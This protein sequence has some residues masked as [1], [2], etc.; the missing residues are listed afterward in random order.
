M[1]RYPRPTEITY[2]Q[3]YDFMGHYFRKFLIEEE[4]GI[5]SKPS[6]SG[7]PM[8]N[9]ILE[10]INLVLGN[11]VRNCNIKQTYVDKYDPW[12]R[13]LDAAAFEIH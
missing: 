12:L 3:V 10:W 2:E 11:I 1:S 8:Y 13:I 7:N 5:I 6:T 4:Y 9:A